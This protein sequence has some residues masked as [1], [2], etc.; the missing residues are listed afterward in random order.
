MKEHPL[1]PEK[2][3]QTRAR[4]LPIYKCYI[5]E[6][7]N[8]A[9][10]AN[11]IVMR[12]HSNENITAGVFLIDLLCL[13][14][15]ECDY[16]FNTPLE[17]LNN[18]SA[19]GLIETDYNTAHNVIYAGHDFAL[20]FEIS[21]H[22]DFEIAKYILEDDDDSIPLM[23]I[24]VGDED[25]NPYLLVN[26]DYNYKPI[27]AKL[28]KH[29]GKDN[30]SF[31]FEEDIDDYDESD[32]EDDDEWDMDDDELNEE[33]FNEIEDGFIDFNILKAY[34]T[35]LLEDILELNSR[36]A[37]DNLMIKTELL[38]RKLEETAPDL[39]PKIDALLSSR[40]YELFQSKIEES[41]RLADMNNDAD[42]AVFEALKAISARQEPNAIAAESFYNLFTKNASNEL[43]TYLL[44]QT[45]PLPFIL[46]NLPALEENM[47]QYLPAGQMLLA[48][49]SLLKHEIVL[50]QFNFL[51]QA[52]QVQEAYPAHKNLHSLHYKCF[53]IFKALYAIKQNKAQDICYYH[54][55]LSIC[56]IGG[57]VKYMYAIQLSK[58]LK[59]H[60][61]ITDEDNPFADD[62]EDDDLFTDD[63]QD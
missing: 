7:W 2:Y 11:I 22:K 37:T 46:M 28:E 50:P 62:D 53:W 32:E 12:Q 39:I 61:N 27:L 8:D 16:I 14:I 19:M 31:S 55:L 57:D 52:T 24:A 6:D 4:N 54:S 60:L 21:P 56:G 63:E 15:K 10:L 45:V 59:A 18:V 36:S 49:Y 26:E 41:Q 5:N 25:G 1:S 48:F 35:E 44:F 43:S 13:G 34:Q 47:H 40:E 42:E 23:E 38:L 58:W 17:E 51:I 9:K 29:A 3:I 30:F 20:H 33:D